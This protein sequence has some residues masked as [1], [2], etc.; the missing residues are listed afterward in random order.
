ML[1]FLSAINLHAV[2]IFDESV[3]GDLS[4]DYLNPNQFNFVNGSN[5]ISGSLAGGSADL[6]LFSF[7]I[8]AGFELSEIN[9][10][11]F[12]GGNNGSFLLLQPGSTLSS[13]PNNS[14]PDPIGFSIFNATSVTSGANLLD[15]ITVG[16]PF[17]FVPS[18]PS[19]EYAAWFN[20]I[21]FPSTYSVDFVVSAVPE[22]SSTFY[23]L[24]L[25]PLSLLRRRTPGR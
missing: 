6:D 12:S 11:D 3:S 17:D 15:A 24:I 19:G 4:D 20:E 25:C 14:F 8:P 18:L 9:V 7:T 13:E 21:D 16:P 22:P 23:F 2:V 5:E 1:L 10:T